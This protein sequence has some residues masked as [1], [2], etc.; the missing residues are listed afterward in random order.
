[1]HAVTFDWM[2]WLKFGHDTNGGSAVLTMFSEYRARNFG[3]LIHRASLEMM[4]FL[5][6]ALGLAST[7]RHTFLGALMRVFRFQPFDSY[8]LTESLGQGLGLAAAR[9]G[10]I[11]C[12]PSG[13]VVSMG[14][15]SGFTRV[16]PSRSLRRTGKTLRGWKPGWGTRFGKVQRLTM[17]RLLRLKATYSSL[18]G[19]ARNGWR[20]N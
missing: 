8:I 11:A 9:R 14:L 16:S 4:L 2:S 18:Q 19:R 7:S 15:D 5:I 20:R 3:S 12:W 17:K 1:M 10:K 6:S 13:F